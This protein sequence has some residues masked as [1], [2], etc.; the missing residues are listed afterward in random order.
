MS[1]NNTEDNKQHS[2]IGDMI[3][4]KQE[5]TPCEQNYIVDN[6]T[7]G[8]TSLAILNDTSKCANCG[9]EGNSDNMNTCNKCKMVKY[10]NAA[11][12][13]KHRKKHKKKCE[14]KVAE[15]HDEQ[16]FKE[17]PPDECPLCLL[18]MPSVDQITF[19][20]CCGKLICNGCIYAMDMS[21][22]KDLCA[23]CRTTPPTS[24]EEENKRLNKLMNNGNAD[25]F[26][27][28][29]SY[30]DSGE[31]GFSQD[32]QKANELFLKAG[33]HGCAAAYFNLGI[34]YDEGMSVEVDTKKAQHYY[35]QAAIMG[36]LDARYSLGRIEFGDG[37][38]DR[39][40]KHFMIAAKAGNEEAL[41]TV[42][43]GFKDGLVTKDEFANTLRAHHERQKEMKSEARDKDVA[44]RNQVQR[45]M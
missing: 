19:K 41:N 24:E 3:S 1:S 28:L 7:N 18:P 44:A 21:G 11:C 9:K 42:K 33:E 6:I 32:Y 35:E 5:C 14:E 38:K 27:Q 45:S 23:F 25:A 17:P 8:I 20:S 39:A 2:S 4:T 37:N 12:K 43:K 10:C 16:L 26:Y 13:K 40:Y 34:T 36:D 30:Y 22:G 29:A 15:L 31:K